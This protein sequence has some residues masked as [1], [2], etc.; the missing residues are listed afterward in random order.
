M[1]NL[2]K[3]E[4]F[5]LKPAPWQRE[6][7]TWGDHDSSKLAEEL[8]H[9]GILVNSR[10]AGEA[11]ELVAHE[12]EFHPIENYLAKL[13]WDKKKRLETWLINYA[14]SKD[15]EFVRAVGGRFLISAIAR[16]RKPGCQCDYCLLLQGP[17]GSLKSSLLRA[18]FGD[19]YFT[20]HIS[21][22]DQKDSRLELRGRWGIELSE[23]NRIRTAS[24]ESVKSFLTSRSDTYRPPYGRSVIAV[25]RSCVFCAT[26]NDETPFTDSSETVAFGRSR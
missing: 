5:T 7:S 3:L 24:L 9:A 10:I 8:Q 11:F 19:E 16:I 15:S 25:P 21:G 17:Q 6:S 1:F 23:L 22:F 2:F 4:S 14:G 18:V 13:R 20:D 12:T 26:S